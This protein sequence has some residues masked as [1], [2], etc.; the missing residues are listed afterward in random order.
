METEHIDS[1]QDSSV[2]GLEGSGV[3]KNQHDF[4]TRCRF[5]MTASVP[6]QEQRCNWKPNFLTAWHGQMKS[7]YRV[8]KQASCKAEILYDL[9]MTVNPS[10]L[11]KTLLLSLQQWSGAELQ[12]CNFMMTR[13]SPDATWNLVC[14]YPKF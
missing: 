13:F 6:L 14:R 10:Q 4:M 11:Y 8:T 12:Y 7:V 3:C 9:Y 1:F 5:T 2:T